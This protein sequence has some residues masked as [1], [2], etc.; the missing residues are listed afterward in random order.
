MRIHSN[1]TILIGPPGTGKTRA[2]IERAKSELAS[3]TAPEAIGY[4]SFTRQAVQE[5]RK[6][7]R[8]GTDYEPSRFTGFRT[9]HSMVYW[10]FGL[11]GSQ[12]VTEE[13]IASFI[14]SHPVPEEQLVS[15]QHIYAYARATNKP[16]EQAWEE[17]H[18]ERSGTQRDFLAWV[19]AYRNWKRYAG[20]RDFV[21][22]IKEFVRRDRTFPFDVLFIDEAQ[23]FSPD[24]WA[25]VQLLCRAAGRVIVAGDPDQSVFG[26]AGADDRMFRNLEGKVEVLEQSYRIPRR[27]FEFSSEILKAMSSSPIYRPTDDAGHIDWLLPDE[28]DRLPFDNGETWF[29]LSRNRC[30]LPPIQELLFE[31]GIYYRNLVVS[32]GN[33]GADKAMRRIGWYNE[34]L[35]G[36]ELH[37]KRLRS[38]SAISSDLRGHLTKKSPWFVAFDHWPLQKI[39]FMKHAVAEEHPNVHVGTFH[40]SKGAEADNVVLLGDITRRVDEAYEAEDRAEYQVLYVAATRAHK[41][42]FIVH[43]QTSRGIP[44]HQFL[45][46]NRAPISAE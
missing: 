19:E 2:L 21:D 6:R 44:W 18:N 8:E 46:P 45:K 40:S 16:L 25:A 24:Q 22:L 27:V 36:V 23:D 10:L 35:M 20:L 15:F 32:A 11:Q 14:A 37:G 1:V 42:L 12:I 17:C 9:L 4:I 33:S 41:R 5:A 34:A 31:R 26:W 28:V 38:L 43:P 13:T 7:I 30:F 39:E 3:G 29:I